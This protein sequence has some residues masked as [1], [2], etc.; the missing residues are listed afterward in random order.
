MKSILVVYLISVYDKR[1][2]LTNFINHYTN[3]TPGKEHDLLICFKNFKKDDP[4]FES[5][6]LKKI[7]HIKYLD[8]NNFNDFDWG[9]YE[10][11]AKA[12]NDKIIFFMNCHSYPIKN[13]WLYYFANNYDD[14]T[15]LGPGGSFES[16][17]NS[18]LN[19]IHTKN[20]IKSYF[21][22]LANLY[23]FPIF[24][25]P[26]LRSNCFMI[27]SESFLKLKFNKKYK[28]KK[29]GTWINESG[30]EGMTNYLKKQ[31]FKIYVINSDGLKFDET[32]WSDSDTYA[33]K[34]Q[35]KLIISDKFSRIFDNSSTEEREK[36]KKYI[37]G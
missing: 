27:S 21:Y 5:N 12:Y 6:Q 24:P 10:R 7:K 8:N 32:G 23:K 22:A 31:K 29:I 25:N 18:A 30:R 3:F 35:D 20:K 19:G 33:C 13:N 9:S 36:I 28:Y 15:V 11:I 14:N 1:E 4:I 26:H 16:M 2:Y 37:W 34:N 17:V